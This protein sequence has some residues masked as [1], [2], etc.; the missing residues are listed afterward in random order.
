MEVARGEVGDVGADD[1]L[2]GELYAVELARPEVG[3]EA[4]LGVGGA[5]A[6]FSGHGG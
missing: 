6:E 5:A 1:E 2:A 4:L 3:P